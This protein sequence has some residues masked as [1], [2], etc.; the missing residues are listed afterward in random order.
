MKAQ[1]D[2]I[3]A[4]ELLE[5]MCELN[6]EKEGW[7]TCI[8]LNNGGVKEEVSF[9]ELGKVWQAPFYEIA[10]NISQINEEDEED[11][12]QFVLCFSL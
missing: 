7:E 8:D 10:I 1:E 2:L 5:V 11:K 3:G 12:G 4:K 6:C 9:V